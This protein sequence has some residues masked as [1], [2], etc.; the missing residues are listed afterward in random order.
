MLAHLLLE[1]KMCVLHMGRA[2]SVQHQ[3]WGLVKVCSSTHGA[4]CFSNKPL[5]AVPLIYWSVSC[6][7]LLLAFLSSMLS[8]HVP[9]FSI[10]QNV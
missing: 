10:T 6:L 3:T 5:A 8:D 2:V 7:P 4:Y 9:S 1:D